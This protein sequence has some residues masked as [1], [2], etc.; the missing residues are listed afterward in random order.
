MRKVK[1]CKVTPM[2]TFSYA[3]Y[4]IDMA[5]REGIERFEIFP[6][7]GNTFEVRAFKKNKME[8]CKVSKEIYQC[9]IPEAF[10]QA[11]AKLRGV[12]S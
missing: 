5:F 8:S 4:H 10:G 6:T 7:L 12:L 1:K 2:Q 9:P 11:I 3:D